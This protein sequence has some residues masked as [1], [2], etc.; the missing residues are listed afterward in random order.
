MT[1]PIYQVDAFAD[2]RF[3]GNP[4]AVVVLESYPADSTL[5]DIAAENNL[6]ETAFI[7]PQGEDYRL[8]WF[9]PTIEV[10]LCG[11][12]TLASAAVVLERLWPGRGKVV[13]HT[14]SGALT[15][16]RIDGGYRM[17]FPVRR[18]SPAELPGL[19]KILGVDVVEEVADDSRN[20]IAQLASAAQV[21]SLAPDLAAIAKL[22]SAGLIVT[23]RGDVDSDVAAGGDAGFDFVSRYFAP[24]HGIP[25]DPVTGSAHC[26]LAYY[27]SQRL[28]KTAFRAFQASPRGG[29]VLC[30]LEGERV[31][32]E[33]SCV[34]Y[35][36]GHI[37]F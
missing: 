29:V 13:F 36:E 12:A 32:L 17:D 28:G 8:R 34:F 20:F 21:R 19:S 4:A 7:V 1:V 37:T 18:T 22:D 3:A 24:G 15:V 26:S 31:I 10:P 23:A 30:R 9:T 2:R 35:L 27:W 33:G 14:A 25:E 6:A 16:E 11:H 5:Q